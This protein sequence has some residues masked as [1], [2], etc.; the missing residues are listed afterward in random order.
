ME[1][2]DTE[3]EKEVDPIQAKDK[4]QDLKDLEAKYPK[5]KVEFCS[6]CTF[7]IEYCEISHPVLVKAKKLILRDAKNT[8]EI[9]VEE[10]KENDDSK[11]EENKEEKKEIS[12]KEDQKDQVTN[13]TVVPDT[14][15]QPD[16]DNQVKKRKKKKKKKK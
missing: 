10:K 1:K 12:I 11:L 9:K 4:N 13:T 6:I 16:D 3:I 14:T 8:E 2:I 5:V 15:S 7:P